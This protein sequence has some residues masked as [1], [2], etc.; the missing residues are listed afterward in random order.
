MYYKRYVDDI[1]II[2]DSNKI[3][4]ETIHNNINNIDQHLEFKMSM[5]ENRTINYLDLAINREINKVNLSIYRKPTYIDITIHASSNHPYDHKIA[6][7]KYYINRML[8][9]PLT[10]Q[11]TQQ[12]WEKIL[13]MAY[14]NGFTERIV[15]KLRNKLSTRMRQTTLTTQTQHTQQYNTKWTTFTYH[16]PAIRKITNLF[17]HTNLKIA[18]RPSNTIYQ[19]LS[20]K[21]DLVNPS[22]I[23]QLKCNTCK[24]L[25]IG[26]PGRPITT[27][28]K[29]HIRYIK[30]N[31]PTSAYA[32]HILNNR[33]E[34]GPTDEILKL[35]IPCTK[36]SRMNCWESLF[37]HM[38]HN[39][40]LIPEQ[41][42]TDS[43]PLFDQAYVPH[44]LQHT[45]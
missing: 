36:G 10:E 2:F 1:L 32:T 24:R 16:S 43:N 25:Y 3:D 18:L 21:S 33:H 17:K 9:M 30:N 22:G 5:E 23:Y 28:Y 42:V 15:H 45:D 31:N 40:I 44:D 12:E 41:Q 34:F 7:F 37:I 27:R 38:H 8:T 4:E 14:N 19:Q 26:Q 39:N 20:Q 11:A 13:Q 35:L 29:E 6:A